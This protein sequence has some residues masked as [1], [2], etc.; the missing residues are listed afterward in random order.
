[1][2]TRTARNQRRGGARGEDDG[3]TRRVTKATKPTRV[4]VRVSAQVAAAASSFLARFRQSMDEINKVF[5]NYATVRAKLEL[6]HKARGLPPPNVAEMMRLCYRGACP[7]RPISRTR[8]PPACPPRARDLVGPNSPPPARARRV[9]SFEFQTPEPPRA[10]VPARAARPSPPPTA[11]GR[12]DLLRAPAP[13]GPRPDPRPRP[14]VS[15]TRA[16]T[17]SWRPSSASAR[18]PDARGPSSG[19]ARDGARIAPRDRRA[20]ATDAA[21]PQVPSGRTTSRTR[22]IANARFCPARGV[23]GRA[24]PPRPPPP[25]LRPSSV[26]PA[27]CGAWR[28]STGSAC[29]YARV[30]TSRAPALPGTA[31]D[32]LEARR[33]RRRPHPPR[34]SQHVPGPRGA[35][36]RLAAAHRRDGD[37]RH[38]HR[39]RAASTTLPFEA[40]ARARRPP[41]APRPVRRAPAHHRLRPRRARGASPGVRECRL[42]RAGPRE[43]RAPRR[44]ATTT[45][46][47]AS[48]TGRRRSSPRASKASSSAS[49]ASHLAR[50]GGGAGVER[51]ARRGSDRRDRERA[52]AGERERGPREEAT[53][54][55]RPS[56]R[57]SQAPVQLPHPPLP[58]PRHQGLVGPRRPDGSSARQRPRR[59]APLRR[60]LYATEAGAQ[61]W[62][63]LGFQHVG[64]GSSYEHLR[65]DLLFERDLR[66]V[67]RPAPA[68]PP[69]TP[70]APSQVVRGAR[71][72]DLQRLQRPLP[73]GPDARR[74]RLRG[75]P[76]DGTRAGL[77]RQGRPD[78]RQRG[79]Q[80]RAP[81]RVA[82]GAIRPRHFP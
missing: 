10:R 13:R 67:F 3:G 69:A 54:R 24:P 56:A 37:S 33:A 5:E 65:F 78:R 12:P 34:P 55:G 35:G 44:S 27:R 39:A 20:R 76:P 49:A 43:S 74:L 77:E 66:V 4:S 80:A 1:M 28:P 38:V 25:G 53:D 18:R 71:L 29:A 57:P 2:G 45:S 11:P 14:Q 72:Q 22:R 82:D 73:D 58:A 62:L 6:K 19:G 26:G 52:S 41:A 42:A 63:A 68:P 15:K 61:A 36:A 23:R 40:S 21:P 51:G 31:G 59:D 46:S 7:P 47:P 64:S 75:R 70:R 81:R 48:S 79:P 30:R 17:S 60:F 8:A 32:S 9:R 50:A 16:S